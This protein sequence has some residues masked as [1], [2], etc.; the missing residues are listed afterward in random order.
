MG[1]NR[2]LLAFFLAI[3]FAVGAI[4]GIRSIGKY[5]YRR[6]P[7]TRNVQSYRRVPGRLRRQVGRNPPS[8]TISGDGSTRLVQ[9]LGY[10]PQS[11]CNPVNTPIEFDITLF[12]DASGK[13]DY[14][15]A[16]AEL[17][18]R[19]WEYGDKWSVV[20][21]WRPWPLPPY[22]A[23][24]PGSVALQVDIR[25]KDEPKA[26]DR[27][28]LNQFSFL[29]DCKPYRSN[30]F[31]CLIAMH[32][33]VLDEEKLD[34]L[35]ADE[36]Q[37]VVTLLHNDQLA[38]DHGEQVRRLGKLHCV[39]RI[40]PDGPHNDRITLR[41]GSVFH[42]DWHACLLQEEGKGVALRVG[43]AHSPEYGD[44]FQRCAK[45]PDDAVA[46]AATAFSVQSAYYYG[47]PRNVVSWSARDSVASCH[48][49]ALFLQQMLSGSGASSKLI[50]FFWANHT[51]GHVLVHAVTAD[52]K[53]PL[54]ID[55]TVGCIYLCDLRE[56]SP[57]KLPAP[58]VL[59]HFRSIPGCDIRS[60]ADPS[61]T[62]LSHDSAE[63]H[64][65]PT[66]FGP[67][68]VILE[69]RPD[70]APGDIA[71]RAGCRVPPRQNHHRPSAGCPTANGGNAGGL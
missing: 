3:L 14:V 7:G 30:L 52:S 12:L 26:I 38:L 55:P 61:T 1:R 16:L 57:D 59:P 43:V 37:L 54:L 20:Y 51:T 47:T 64:V 36:L 10:Q 41:S 49:L 2:R 19:L 50:R 65:F 5:A 53:T 24:A 29:S 46:A 68:E 45:L 48:Q 32:F 4:D 28:W 17:E 44:L 66:R 71:A 11:V 18:F 27:R 23:S 33:D 31:R 34:A 6:A 70:P 69:P 13:T 42:W 39:G 21:D 40:A 60:L 58:I 63:R 9:S 25:R 56:I 22:R 35:L 15:K 67:T 62:I 8:D